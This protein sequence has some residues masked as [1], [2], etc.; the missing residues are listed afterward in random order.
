MKKHLMTTIAAILFSA[1][2]LMAGSDGAWFPWINIVGLAVFGA[3]A[4]FSLAMEG[5]HHGTLIDIGDSSHRRHDR[6]RGDLVC[7][8][9][10]FHERINVQ[11]DDLTD[12]RLGFFKGSIFALLICLPFWVIVAIVI[13]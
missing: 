9:R 5:G 3:S 2:I 1:G 10:N 4:I 8:S 6:G 12:D 13:F 7:L 11:M